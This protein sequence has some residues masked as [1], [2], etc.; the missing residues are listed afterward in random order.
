[1]LGSSEPLMSMTGNLKIFCSLVVV[2][3][4]V[5][6]GSQPQKKAST[7][8]SQ[9]PEDPLMYNTLVAEIAGHRG[10]LEKSVDYYQR[11]IGQTNDLDI[12]KRAA[13]VM[14]FSKNYAAARRAIS[15]WMNLAPKDIEARQLAATASLYE[16]DRG[17]SVQ[18]LEWLVDQAKNIPQGFNIAMTLLERV[19]DKQLARD[20]MQEISG[21]YPDIIQGHVYLARLS[22]ALESYEEAIK[23]AEKAL[24]INSEN[25][26][27][28][29][30][31][32][33][34]EIE[35]GNT[36]KALAALDRLLQTNPDNAELRLTYARILMA[37]NRYESAIRQFEI[38]L[39]KS[40]ENAD[41]IYSAALLYMQVKSYAS[42]EKFLNKLLD[43]GL[44]EQEALYYLGRLEEKRKHFEKAKEW[45]AQVDTDSLYID[46]QM[47][48]ARVQG[49]AG[50]LA[51][52]HE[53]YQ[54]LRESHPEHGPT[55]WLSE[56]DMLREIKDYQAAFDL[57]VQ[58]IE[59]Y[60][61]NIDLIYSR[62][63]A[64]EKVDRIDILESDLRKVLDREPNHAHA[65]NALGYT[66]A[67]RTD[68]YDE[69]LEYI[70]RAYALEP[71]D[72]AIIDSMGWVHYRLGDYDKAIEFL[73]LANEVMKDGEVAAH[74]GEVLW[75][76]GD[77]EAA[78]ALWK[79]A[80]RQYPDS[81]ILM[82]AIKRFKP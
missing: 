49:K 38:L 2:L 34:A 57:L 62:A 50:E 56:S 55:I 44:H 60:P 1:M 63:L 80:V 58:A 51:E 75:V 46:A 8:V 10:N 48:A 47:A 73:T 74:L 15:Q 65:L 81:E 64:A 19:S 16:G 29:I 12:I 17:D 3:L 11:V 4:M 67:D 39:E 78:S 77:H 14:L 20:V 24:E 53:R 6:C 13:R 54:T 33:R 21:H 42:A 45:Y 7:R 18:H 28:Q 71:N 36:D 22:H 9:E 32:A 25:A 27:A 82:R 72:P 68:R 66:L 30:I 35:L 76:S 59:A 37:V 40:P 5:G 23:S 31:L 69:A 26:D 70:K 61:D 79:D 43:I 52:A 41:L